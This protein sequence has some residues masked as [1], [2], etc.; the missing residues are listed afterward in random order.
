MDTETITNQILSNCHDTKQW[1][2]LADEVLTMHTY[3]TMCTVLYTYCS[4][5]RLNKYLRI[6]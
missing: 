1:L 5:I 2:T 3:N 4:G 6:R